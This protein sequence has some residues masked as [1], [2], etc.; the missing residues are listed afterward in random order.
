MGRNA[1]DFIHRMETFHLPAMTV[2]AL[3][4]QVNVMAPASDPANS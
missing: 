3:A 4:N 2:K 1:V